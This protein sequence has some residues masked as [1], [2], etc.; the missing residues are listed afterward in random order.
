MTAAS[1]SPGENDNVA[2]E[3]GPSVDNR[4]C[5]EMNEI[6][7][8]IVPTVTGCERSEVT[9]KTAQEL[10]ERKIPPATSAAVA[11]TTADNHVP[12]AASCGENCSTADEKKQAAQVAEAQNKEKKKKLKRA[13]KAEKKR[14]VQELQQAP[15]EDPVEVE[16]RLKK[17]REE[18]LAPDYYD[19]CLKKKDEQEEERPKELHIAPM[20]D[21]TTREFRTFMRIL[22]KKQVLWTEMVYT[23][24]LICFHLK[25]VFLIL[26]QWIS[27]CNS[28]V[29][30]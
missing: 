18:N 25:S 2:Q 22:S 26:S 16:R 14:A 3:G 7:V 11:T 23:L 21:V 17:W 24:T 28:L 12:E 20:L 6:A 5:G 8:T 10:S 13:S 4:P 27:C 19:N 9:E 29:I 1:S 15:P 30:N